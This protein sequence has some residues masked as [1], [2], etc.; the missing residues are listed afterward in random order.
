[1]LEGCLKSIFSQDYN[2]KDYEVIVV[3]DASS[4]GTSSIV[5]IMA[6]KHKNLR[7]IR[8]RQNM[9]P[10]YSRNQGIKK[11]RG[12]IIAFTDDDCSVDNDWLRSIK[13]A[14]KNFP[15]EYGIGGKI[16]GSEIKS[17]IL[18]LTHRNLYQMLEKTNEWSEYE[19]KLRF[20]SKHPKMSWWRFLR[21][22]LTGFFKSYLLEK[23]YK[24]GTAGII[25]SIYQS[26]SMF[27]T[28]AKLWEKQNR[29]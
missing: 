29:H 23:G 26:F 19:A 20:D 8:N 25:E 21:I 15:Q 17:P 13:I 4:D 16:I 10:A 3:D 22:M 1:M 2:T 5:K 11:S 7:L 12:N 6:K 28:Y 27:I 14:H 18:H 24:N 9:G